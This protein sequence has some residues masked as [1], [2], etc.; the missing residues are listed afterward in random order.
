MTLGAVFAILAF[1]ATG[2]ETSSGRQVFT[3]HLLEVNVVDGR[4]Q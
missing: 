1:E 4:S 2:T 3:N